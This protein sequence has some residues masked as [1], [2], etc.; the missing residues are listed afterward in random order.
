MKEELLQLPRRQLSLQDV[1]ETE[2]KALAQ[3]QLVQAKEAAAAVEDAE[4]DAASR[5]E[6]EELLPREQRP[7]QRALR[8]PWPA[9]R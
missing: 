1:L 7:N 5:L 9:L 2:A 6:T 4:A 8:K 3:A